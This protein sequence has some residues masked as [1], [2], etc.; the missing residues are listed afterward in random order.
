[1]CQSSSDLASLV[2]LSSCA[3]QLLNNKPAQKEL[4]YSDDPFK[5]L[6][7]ELENLR[8]RA[9]DH[10]PLQVNAEIVAEC[11]DE[12]LTA[13]TELPSDSDILAEFW[14]DAG[15][16]GPDDNELEEEDKVVIDEPAPKRPSKQELCH[17]IDVL[18]TFSLG[19]VC[20]G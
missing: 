15:Q 14:P 6:D 16:S 2:S 10:A 13:D 1:M 17:A 3:A 4:V 18:R 12:L 9:Q 8:E 7:E 5:E 19:F 11:D 20:R